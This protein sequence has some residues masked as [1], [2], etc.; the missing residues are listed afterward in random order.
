M[1]KAQIVE[2]QKEGTCSLSKNVGSYQFKCSR[3]VNIY[4]GY[5]TLFK[6]RVDWLVSGTVFCR[7][8]SEKGE[9]Y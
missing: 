7:N 8:G 2:T 4:G 6:T 9:N 1:L 3:K 5:Y